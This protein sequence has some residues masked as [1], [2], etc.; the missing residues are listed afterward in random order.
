MSARLKIGLLAAGVTLLATAGGYGWWCSTGPALPEVDLTAA[1]PAVAE[2]I[3]AAQAEVRGSP[4]SGRAW[5]ELGMALYANDFGAQAHRCFIE[6]ERLDAAAPLWPYLQALRLMVDDR[7]AAVDALRRAVA[8]TRPGDVQHVAAELALAEALFERDERTEAAE[9][10]RQALAADPGN[11]RAEFNLGLIALAEDRPEACIEY[12]SRSCGSKHAA[13]RSAA[14]LAAA[15]QRL[16]DRASAAVFSRRAREQSADRPWPDPFV[17]EAQQYAA[18][19]HRHFQEAD[20]LAGTTHKNEYL[21]ALHGLATE[22]GDGISHYRLGLALV[23]LDEY[24]AAEP[25]LRTA[26]S[27]SP[28]LVGAHYLLGIALLLQGQA[29]REQHSAAA[30]DAKLGEAATSLRRATELKPTHGQA[31]LYLGR[32]LEQIRR[33]TEALAEYRV[34]VQCCPEVA[35]AQLA[36]G[37]A[38]L[39]AGEPAEAQRH[40]ELALSLAPN[41][42]RASAAM[43][44]LRGMTRAP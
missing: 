19:P 31:H 43:K 32:A 3:Q 37:A 2:A 15:Y 38:L 29:L 22:A 35:E 6:A 12:L 1:S 11:A 30:A 14:Y 10:C 34:A 23:Q 8:R 16:G 13:R 9:L 40:L 36:L 4:R 25:V 39:T 5:G 28:D 20:K 18:G 44:R 21:R 7:E 24:A 17:D 42:P 26:L 33:P 27:K 41:D